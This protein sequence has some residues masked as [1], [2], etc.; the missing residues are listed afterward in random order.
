MTH[1]RGLTLLQPS[2]SLRHKAY[3]V[4]SVNI[5][6]PLV[7]MMAKFHDWKGCRIK[8]PLELFGDSRRDAGTLTRHPNPLH[9][10]LRRLSSPLC[11]ALEG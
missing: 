7:T 6:A 11:R 8:L 4:L 1:M 5:L 3:L 2:P 9:C 10:S